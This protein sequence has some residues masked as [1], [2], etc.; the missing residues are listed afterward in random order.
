M[1]HDA[2]KPSFTKSAEELAALAAE[3][4]ARARDRDDRL[5]SEI[6]EAIAESRWD[7]ICPRER[8]MC[9]GQARTSLE[10]VWRTC[11]L[12]DEGCPW[13]SDRKAYRRANLLGKMGFGPR[14]QYADPSRVCPEF[15]QV[16]ETWLKDS[17]RYQREG[18]GLWLGGPKGVGKTAAM[19]C[20]AV[21][22]DRLDRER[23]RYQDP[24]VL[25]VRA[26]T[27]FNDLAQYVKD[28]RGLQ[29]PQAFGVRHLI[30][31]DIGTE[32][33]AAFPMAAFME[34]ADHRYS[35]ALCTHITSNVHKAEL[36]KLPTWARVIDRWTEATLACW[37]PGES[38]RHAPEVGE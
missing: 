23:M 29:Y 16:I 6:T 30:I 21:A 31:D 8:S 20:F 3:A 5:M 24:R 13:A 9:E 10:R 36:E 19:A 22:L 26:S 2:A 34:L 28:R 37:Y 4:G 1:S 32:Y 17:E 33:D 14:F 35:E 38:M 12:A 18:T 11:P 27:L 7:A 25:F 15:R